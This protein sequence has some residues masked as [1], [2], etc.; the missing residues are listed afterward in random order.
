MSQY[1]GKDILQPKLEYMHLSLLS[2]KVRVLVV[3][4]G[5]AGYIKCKSFSEK[6]CSVTVVSKDFSEEFKEFSPSEVTL[7]CGEYN[8]DYILDK[9]MVVIAVEDGKLIQEITEDCE[10][11]SKLYLNCADFKE[12]LLSVPLQRETESTLFSISTKGGNPKTARFLAEVIE[13]GIREYDELISYSSSLRE[14]I[15]KTPY[16]DEIMT[17][18]ASEDFKFFVD[19]AVQEKVLRIFYGGKNFEYKNSDTEK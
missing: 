17:F 10:K 15:K 2:N 11:L 19:K 13:K 3:G 14:R 1:T 12:G 7:I 9:H 16:K 5:R 8:S 6:G 4:G 18:T